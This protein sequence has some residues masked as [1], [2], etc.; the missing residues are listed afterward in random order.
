MA[1]L[2]RD[3]RI[4]VLIETMITGNTSGAIEGQEARGQT[5]LVNSTALPKK[6]LHGTTR[7]QLES[8]GIVFGSSQDVLFIEA[9]LPAG[10][11]KRPTNHS[12]WSDLVD[13]NNRVRASIFYK[14]AFYDRSAHISLN[15]FFHLNVRSANNLEYGDYDTETEPLV[16]IVTN[17]AK[18]ELWRSEP[19]TP[20]KEFP[21]Y[22][23]DEIARN[24]GVGWLSSHYPNW[25]DP[26]A[27]WD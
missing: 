10:W 23:L 5:A 25:K 21:W 20:T 15:T 2:P 7:E 17:G 4:D 8:M 6:M 3:E 1:L 27:Y 16:C 13:D 24:K 18:E 12:M 26:L 9:T 11:T 22:E 14:A 19:L